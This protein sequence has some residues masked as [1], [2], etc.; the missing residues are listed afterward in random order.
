MATIVCA[1]GVVAALLLLK[2]ARQASSKGKK[3]FAAAA[4]AVAGLAIWA[5]HFISMLGYKTGVPVTYE[6]PATLASLGVI[7]AGMLSYTAMAVEGRARWRRVTGMVVVAAA[8][9]AMHFV[10]IAAMSLD[11]ARMALDPALVTG[12]IFTGLVLAVLA[13]LPSTSGR[14]GGLPLAAALLVA[15]VASFHF[16]SMSAIT[17]LPDPTSLATG[18]ISADV[19]LIVLALVMTVVIAIAAFVM[20][21]AYW[22]RT[23]ALGHLRQAIDAMPDALGFYDADDRLLV[24]NSRYAEVNPGVAQSLR[25]GMLFREALGIDMDAGVYAEAEGREGSWIAERMAARQLLSN[26]ME[27][28]L[29]DGRWLRVQD[30]K[31]AAGGTVTVCTDISDLKRDALALEMARDEAETANRTKSEFLANMSH[32]IRTPLNGVIGLAQALDRTELSPDQREMLELIQSSGRT[33]QALL[34][35]ILDLA[36]VESGRLELASETFDLARAVRDAGQLYASAAKAKGLQFFIE[37]DPNAAI[38]VQGDSI[39]LKQ[40]LTNL[41]SNAVKFTTEGFVSL[42][43]AQSARTDGTPILRFTVEDTGVG[44]DAEARA[45]LFTRF[46]QA[47]G[48][49][50]RRFGGTGLGLAICRELVTMMDGDL[51]CES[52]PEGGSAFIMTLPLQQV[53]AP[54][55]R[56]ERPDAEP[57]AGEAHI[58]RVLLADDHATN[59]RVVELILGQAAVDLTSVE[60]GAQ[61]VAACQA[62]NFDLILMDMQMPVMDGLT[63][64]REIRLHEAAIGLD[65]TPI[66]MLTANALPDHVAASHAAGADHHLAK[67]FNAAE[68]LGLVSDLSAQARAMAA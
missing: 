28:K 60:D 21:V 18:G 43:V 42:T 45:R 13:G 19:F 6:I 59:R 7:L 20:G 27:Q 32:E 44:F 46:E 64:T 56:I 26:T 51:D 3:L 25:A 22:S 58:I 35:D 50:T 54:P 8:I 47:D 36:R 52:E 9:A 37:I 12:S 23:N 63:A 40:V 17:I 62:D 57:E 34:S 49:I 15:S 10:G 65:R 24:W 2:L 48:T 66:V 14:V 30:R 1:A 39:R 33:L 38:W 53:E 4:A 61:A 41:V 31:T 11:G 16:G 67:P 55:V 68:L 5:T 29:S